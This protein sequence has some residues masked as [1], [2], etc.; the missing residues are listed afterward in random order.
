MSSVR[1]GQPETGLHD[2]P[3]VGVSEVP[4]YYGIW[5]HAYGVSEVSTNACIVR[6]SADPVDNTTDRAI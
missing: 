6:K 3:S 4:T 5:D 2:M 1:Q